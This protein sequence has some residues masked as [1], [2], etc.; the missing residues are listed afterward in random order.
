MKPNKETKD[1]PTVQAMR[2]ATM[3]KMGISGQKAQE[4]EKGLNKEILSKLMWTGLKALYI[5][6][7][8]ALSRQRRLIKFWQTGR[9]HL[10]LMLK[11]LSSMIQ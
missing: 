4:K 6:E 11:W 7:L 2:C 1:V 5:I 9:G 10:W 3:P 8:M